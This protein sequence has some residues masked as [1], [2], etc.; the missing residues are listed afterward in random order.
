L[1]RKDPEFPDLSA[2]KCLWV[3]DHPCMSDSDLSSLICCSQANPEE[4]SLP[5]LCFPSSKLW[6]SSVALQK[7]AVKS[8]SPPPPQCQSLWLV[9][10]IVNVPICTISFQAVFVVCYIVN[11]THLNYL[12]AM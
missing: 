2:V 10:Y 12:S 6:D 3:M 5:D 4:R 11:V 9:H 1:S 7:Q 8:T